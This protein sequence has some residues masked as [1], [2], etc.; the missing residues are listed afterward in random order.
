MPAFKDIGKS[1]NDLFD[2]DEYTLDRSVSFEANE[3]KVNFSCE[4]TQNDKGVT[5]EINYEQ[6]N[7]AVTLDTNSKQ[8]FTY[9]NVNFGGLK[10]EFKLTRQGD[11]A[12]SENFEGKLKKSAK[13]WG[14][15]LKYNTNRK[16]ACKATAD[17]AYAKDAFTVGAKFGFDAASSAITKPSVGFQYSQGDNTVAVSTSA[18]GL[19]DFG[20]AFKAS[21]FRSQGAD[22]NVGGEF[23][24]NGGDTS[25]KAG[26]AKKIDDKSKFQGFFDQN[27]DFNGR[28][29]YKFTNRLNAAAK[30]NFNFKNPT[31]VSTGFSLDFQ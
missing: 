25:F 8:E 16:F 10:N 24:Y 27:F 2:S 4:S 11:E 14:L 17:F 29:G 1:A 13:D 7:V 30:F 18:K 9:K 19:D 20:Q 22:L 5:T 26:F 28:F 31:N 21:I 3:D 6:G 15:T 23:G 12:E